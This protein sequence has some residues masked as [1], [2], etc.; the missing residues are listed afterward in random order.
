MQLSEVETNYDR[1]SRYYDSL[2]ELVFGRILGVEKCRERT[3]ELLGDIQGATVLDVGCGT[4]RNFGFLVERVSS[5]GRVIAVDY[6]EG[7]LEKARD[8]VRK[9]GWQN[10]DVMRGDAVRLAGVPEG[11]DAV[12]SAWCY[13]IVYDL[14]GALNRALEVLRPGGAIAI[15]DFD[16]SKPTRGLL[17]TLFP[18]YGSLLKIAGIDTAEDLD[19]ERLQERWNAG[20]ELLC[21]R[22]VGVR[23][24]RY[25]QGAGFILAGR[26]SA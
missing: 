6:S 16:R 5:T 17:R 25:L 1:A 14:E 11:V 23:E 12:V 3:I 26:K 4:G 9:N 15:M 22:L 8:R 10:V 7:M 20:Q 19:N 2:T 18:L 21:S 13:G 24:E